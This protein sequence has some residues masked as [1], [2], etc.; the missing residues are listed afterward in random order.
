[1]DF[2][3]LKQT[4]LD[5]HKCDLCKTR[6]QV[7]FGSGNPQ[8][9]VLFIG[10][11]PGRNEDEQGLPFVGRSGQLLDQYLAAIHLDRATDLF[12]TNIVKCRPPENRDPLPNEWDACMPYLREQFKLIRP[13]IV[14]C[15]GRI[16]AQRL[17][18]PDFSV[19]KEHGQWTEKNGTFFT[20]T[21]H[22]AALL[23]NPGNKAAA[24][25]D[26]VSLREKI[27]EVCTHTYPD[28]KD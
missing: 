26:Y 12:I 5:C 4:C 1:M 22:P 2:E 20:A 28:Q 23:R 14:V 3:T 13:K 15:L 8:A 6:T 10:E 21:L 16:A 18:R 19:M 9:E 11:A 17:I 24:Y 27:R 7:V 25:A